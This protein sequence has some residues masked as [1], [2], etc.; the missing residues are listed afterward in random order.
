MV[1]YHLRE[2]QKI[3]FLNKYTFL[4]VFQQKILQI[5]SFKEGFSIFQNKLKNQHFWHGKDDKL[6]IPIHK[7]METGDQN[8]YVT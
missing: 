2:F 6:S 1:D 7:Y 4:K 8:I 3:I 5:K